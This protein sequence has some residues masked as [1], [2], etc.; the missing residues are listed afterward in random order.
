MFF[1]NFSMIWIILLVSEENLNIHFWISFEYFQL[2]LGIIK[3]FSFFY[4]QVF[5]DSFSVLCFH[6]SVGCCLTHTI[7]TSSCISLWYCFYYYFL[8]IFSMFVPDIL[9]MFLV[10]LWLKLFMFF[11]H[12]LFVLLKKRHDTHWKT[13]K[14]TPKHTYNFIKEMIMTY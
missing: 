11:S 14:K 2:L 4:W 6:A 7:I 5:F 10:C 8:N 9:L 12:L 1:S 13:R 3:R